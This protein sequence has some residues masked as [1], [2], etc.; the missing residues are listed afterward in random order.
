[1]KKHKILNGL[2]FYGTVFAVTVGVASA[3]YYISYQKEAV[4]NETK[5]SSA[6]KVKISFPTPQ[7]PEEKPKNQVAE[8]TFSAKETEVAKAEESYKMPTLGSIVVPYNDTTL[9]YSEAFGDWRTH[10]SID[11]DTSLDS[12]VWASADG[13]IK[14]IYTHP[15]YGKTVVI[16][17]GDNIITTY[18][19][20]EP[21]NISEGKSVKA[22]E[23]IGICNTN[24]LHFEAFL[25]NKPFNPF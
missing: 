22:G 7:K 17:H 6:Q 5:K 18:A 19:P 4:Q 13:K 11:F 12:S 20:I 9:E 1:M 21:K 14:K 24:T 10:P 3:G 2:L 16:E 23:T 8:N 15:I 25:E